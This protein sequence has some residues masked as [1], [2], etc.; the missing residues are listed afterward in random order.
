AN[1]ALFVFALLIVLSLTIIFAELEGGPA[2][3][4]SSKTVAVLGVLTAINASFRMLDVVTDVV[5]G[6][7]SPVYFL[8]ILCGYVYGGR[9]GFL[10]GALSMLVGAILTGGVGPWLPYQMFGV[11]WVGLT[12]GWLPKERLRGARGLRGRGQINA[13]IIAL[14][15]FGLLWG[16][17]YGAIL[18]LFF[19]P[20]ATGGAGYWTPGMSLQDTVAQYAVFYATTSLWW[21]LGSAF[22][23]AA[24]ILLYGAAVL[25]VLRRFQRRFYF[26]TI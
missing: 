11:G 10:L 13:E 12:A 2:G 17:L 9:F 4:A 7:F 3:G 6:G 19:W 24:I 8:V 21:D 22:G 23:N 18:N 1:D 25:K 15:A 26:E 5:L 16:I 20:Y 14:A